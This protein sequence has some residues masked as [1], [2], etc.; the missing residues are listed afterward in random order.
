MNRL[1]RGAEPLTLPTD[2]PG[3]A[4]NVSLVGVTLMGPKYRHTCQMLPWLIPGY[5]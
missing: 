4:I 5:A 2:A 1:R 3:P